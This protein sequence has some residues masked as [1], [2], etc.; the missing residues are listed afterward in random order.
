MKGKV[1]TALIVLAVLVLAAVQTV[2]IS[3]VSAGGPWS[4]LW[5]D[6]CPAWGRVLTETLKDGRT[7]VFCEVWDGGLADDRAF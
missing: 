4:V 1:R 5:K 7:L 2:W 3:Q 6:E